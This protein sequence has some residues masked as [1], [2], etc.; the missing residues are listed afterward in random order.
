MIKTHQRTNIRRFRPTSRQAVAWTVIMILSAVPGRSCEDL[1][2][3]DDQEDGG[4]DAKLHFR[5]MRSRKTETGLENDERNNEN[6]EI[7][8]E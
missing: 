7:E 2:G 8:G 1:S 5:V 3:A 4:K 6:G